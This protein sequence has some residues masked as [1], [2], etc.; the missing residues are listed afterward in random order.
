MS[1]FWACVVQFG[2]GKQWVDEK[3]DVKMHKNE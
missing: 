1:G 3:R 2:E